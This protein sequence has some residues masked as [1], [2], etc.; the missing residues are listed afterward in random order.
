[1]TSQLATGDIKALCAAR[2][3]AATDQIRD[4]AATG[5][6]RCLVELGAREGRVAT[7][8]ADLGF[9]QTY[10][11]DR[12]HPTSDE[13]RATR[14][15]RVTADL[16]HFDV[17]ALTDASCVVAK[18]VC[19]VA[20]DYSVRMVARA[21]PEVF[22][23]APC[24]Y[25]SCEYDAYPGRE[26]LAELGVCRDARDFDMLKKLTQWGP[27][28]FSPSTE[29]AGLWAMDLIDA[30]RV[31]FLRRSGLDAAALPYADARLALDGAL[32][33][34]LL[35]GWRPPDVDVEHNVDAEAIDDGALEETGEGMIRDV[36]LPRMDAEAVAP[37]PAS[38]WDTYQD[39]SGT[40]YYHNRE[41][42]ETAWALPGES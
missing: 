16:R 32:E 9:E 2:A 7:A 35:V 24:C 26:L 6:R 37:A 33:C 36:T 14:G 15:E 3:A 30:G 21:R 22:A 28:Q 31:D 23:F 18:H 4:V 19:G 39:E 10:L 25:F 8:L 38:P 13:A 27:N 11:V 12:D 42:G 29:A 17:A 41:T 5:S 20:M 34:T 40:P 1:M